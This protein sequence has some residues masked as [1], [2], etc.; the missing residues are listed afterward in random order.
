MTSYKKKIKKAAINFLE[1]RG[2]EVVKEYP[3]TKLINLV[4]INKYERTIVFVNVKENKKAFGEDVVDIKSIE[5]FMI[6]FIT[7]NEKYVDMKM[8][9][10]CIKI[11]V[12]N[13]DRCL[14]RHTIN[15]MN[16]INSIRLNAR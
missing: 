16:H 14:I 8:R 9:Y 13:N 11:I 10:D 15:A 4:C 3:M 12:I 1:S 7:K 5:K 6:D 2:Y